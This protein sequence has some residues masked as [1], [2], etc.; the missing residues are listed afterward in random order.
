MPEISMYNPHNI[1][2]Q[3]VEVF[4]GGGNLHLELPSS[5]QKGPQILWEIP[6]YCTKPIIRLKFKANIPGNHTAYIR[7]KITGIDPSLA[8]RIL[9][10]PIEVEIVQE[11]GIYSAMS[12]LDF[13]LIGSNDAP[14]KYRINLENSSNLNYCINNLSVESDDKNVIKC[15]TLNYNSVDNLI[16]LKMIGQH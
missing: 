6:S 11:A 4:S 1:P 16:Y 10:V 14:V 7:I 2:L 5:G 15:V 13:G 9:V 8:D 3:I 12:L